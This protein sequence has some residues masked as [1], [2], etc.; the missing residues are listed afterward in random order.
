[1]KDS[2]FEAF[3]DPPKQFRPSPFWSWNDALREEELRWQVREMRD[4]GFGGYFMHSRVGLVTEYLSEEWMRMIGA[5]LDEGKRVDAE[6]WLYDED[7]WPSGFA[8]GLVPGMSREFRARGLVATKLT[9]SELESA[10]SDPTVLAVFSVRRRA[11]GSIAE[12][13]RVHPGGGRTVEGGELFAFRVAEAKESNWY[14]GETYVDLLSP[15]V[16]EAFLRVTHDAY[17][18]RFG[19]H[20]GE[21]MPGIFTDEPNYS[22]EGNPPWTDEFRDYFR[23]K[24]GYD[25]VDHLPHLY[26]PSEEGVKARHDY[27]RTATRRFVEAFS[28]PLGE[29]CEKLGLKLTG[30]YLSEDTLAGQVRVIGAAM[31]HYEYMHVPGIDHLCR[32]IQNPL[33][34][35]QVSS[36]SRQFGRKRVMC[37]IFGC[38]GHTMTFEDQKW[39]SDFHFALG[40]TFLVPHLT[41]YSMP[42]DRK[43]DYPPTLSYHQPYWSE[44]KLI[45]DYLSR[46]S[47]MMS[48]GEPVVD[49][50]VLHSIPSAWATYLSNMESE[51]WAKKSAEA[52]RYSVELSKVL[53]HLTSG[54]RDFD[55]GDEFIM[56]RH[57]K[58]EGASLRIGSMRYKV[59]IVPPS[60][61]WSSRTVAL[62]KEFVSAGG[63]L[64]FVGEVPTMVDAEP[65]QELA[66]MLA[67]PN[68][69]WVL[70]ERDALLSALDSCV[71][72][73]VSI[74]DADGNE[75]PD[76]YCQHRLDGPRH[77]LF[78]SSRNRETTI[79]AR[80]SIKARGQVT[81]WD[82]A[83]G[84]VFEVR[85][86][87]SGNWTH[88]DTTFPPAGSRIFVVGG[89]K[90]G[91][92]RLPPRKERVLKVIPL[93]D[94]WTLRRLHPNS[95]TLDYCTYRVGNS[96]WQGPVPVWKARQAIIRAAGLEKHAGMQ[97]WALIK[98]GIRPSPV[99]VRMKFKFNVEEVPKTIAFVAEKIHKFSLT[100]NG[101]QVGTRTNGWHWDKQF[102]KIDI[103]SNVVTGTNEIEL[104]CKYDADVEIEDS[105]L[106]GDFGVKR[107]DPGTYVITRE[108]TKLMDGS[109]VDQGYPFY[110][111]NMAYAKR[112]K[113][114]LLKRSSYVLRLKN[115]RGTLFSVSL[116]G[117]RVGSL[118]KQPWEVELTRLVKKDN[119]LEIE[120][121]SSLR[122]TFGPLHHRGGDK[123]P[124]TG[125]GEFV[126][127]R[128]WT[129]QYQFAPY[130]LLEG[131][132]VVIRG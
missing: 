43:R 110:C 14:N 35:K 34:L 112:F 101:A 25:I 39:I 9:D 46:C 30:H 23:E 93:H 126:D 76:L 79:P 7:K 31:P 22:P 18:K 47:M 104:S 114:P 4:K 119:F 55:F 26:F 78:V 41:L 88:I 100:V 36:A 12:M 24:N 58:V 122:N 62:I 118:W 113:L 108:P 123:L 29:R 28:I 51:D 40:I 19:D 8:G 132:E 17:A 116:N 74:R 65:S 27:W 33:T 92:K 125:P 73:S 59:V 15:K 81:E 16:T 71:D 44:Y 90:V 91:A 57:A 111:G 86:D 85:A 48:Q 75:I 107:T 105:F 11:D 120:V 102:G 2:L 94:G 115:P 61:T 60:L 72:R 32:N 83:T 95:L 80:V 97:P 13:S 99:E 6:S 20:F 127:E 52:N 106:V 87:V 77:I 3:R 45:N 109:W 130:G 53:E 96:A 89:P 63:K 82:A 117:R 42:G 129:D 1:M 5:C 69:R 84:E 56:E 21:Y 70:N 67:G 54:H 128:N 50:L 131:A 103:T 37:E 10:A 64:I 66:D 49:V 38:S 98:K 124:W 121:F 68:A